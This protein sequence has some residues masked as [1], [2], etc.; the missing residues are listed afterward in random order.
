M[1]KRTGFLLS[2]FV[3][4]LVATSAY[5]VTV[6]KSYV[7][8]SDK[9]LQKN[10]LTVLGMLN[11]KDA[12]KKYITLNTEAKL[13][14][15]AINELFALQN[16]LK[17]AVENKQDAGE[18]L[19][20]DDLKDLSDAIA[21]LES[22]KVD[23]ETIAGIQQTIDNL[24]NTYATTAD[25]TAADQVLLDK[26]NA[27]D[28]PNLADYVKKS[29][30]ATVAITGQY[31]D[32]EGT[33]E[34][35]SIEGLATSTELTN[36]Q[37]A[38][39]SA[40]AE[41]QEKG[42]YLTAADLTELSS[43]VAALESGK[44]DATTV[45]SI[46]ETIGKL[47][48]T[49][50]S[51]SEL[52]SA[53]ER[54]QAAID[55]IDLT[56]YA[57]TAYVNEALA[58]KADKSE[59]TTLATTEALNNLQ[60]TLQAAINEKQAAGDYLTAADLTELSSAVAALET[61]KAD[62]STVS[63]IQETIGK[64]GD[65]YASKSELTSAEERLQAAIS[66]IDLTAYAKTAD[67]NAALLLKE[68]AA[69]KLS[70]ATA[71]EIEA[72][73]SDEKARMYPSVA[74]SQT[75]ANAAVTKVNEVAGDLST[76]QTQVETNTADIK[77]LNEA[78]YLT[79]EDA[80]DTYLTQENATNTYLT[81]ENAENTYLTQEY[82]A[83]NYVTQQNINQFV[84]IPDGSITAAKLNASTIETGAMAMLTVNPET[85]KAEWVSVRIVD[86]PAELRD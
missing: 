59:L 41:K 13:A 18:Y 65:T 86:D 6:S 20:A 38:L 85:G 40:I 68:D 44:A 4:N 16:E 72:M 62:A 74:V 42:D 78:G 10:I 80:A 23:S 35:P 69:N 73:S 56:A 75:I 26:I 3:A 33:P 25:M 28:I 9:T 52:T 1:I 24:G 84:D 83:N 47:G 46:Q 60:L 34:I 14:I 64:L 15:P 43:A 21:E 36:L 29:E 63:S 79:Q 11:E 76:L 27:I 7:D 31:A 2:F 8:S 17:T 39:E 30:L 12:N 22:G 32:L 67:V 54:L 55:N 5:S 19:V 48:D 37:T 66:N 49:Y 53:E 50:A 51:K 77:A 61:G 82:A 81:Q 45:S 70:S 71:A 57:T 58:S